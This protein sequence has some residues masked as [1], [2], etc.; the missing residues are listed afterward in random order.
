[1]L[2]VFPLGLL[3]TSL[4]FDIIYLGTGDGTWTNVS[5]YLIGAGVL[6]GLLAAVPGL[7]DWLSIPA[8]TRAKSIGLWHGLGNVLV[9]VLFIIN[10][11][12]RLPSPAETGAGPIVLSFIG[13]G[14]GAVTGWLGGELVD[15]LGI[16]VDEGANPDAPSSLSHQSP[17]EPGTHRAA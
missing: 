13:I 14:I 3:V 12:L 5:E 2:V 9:V 1:M 16:G 8:G 7:I 4:I 17:M 10:W 15:R 6:G 11:F